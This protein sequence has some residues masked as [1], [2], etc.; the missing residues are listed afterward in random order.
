MAFQDDAVLEAGER[1]SLLKPIKRSISTKPR[2]TLCLP[3]KILLCMVALI[4]MGAFWYI[5]NHVDQRVK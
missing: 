2:E 1:Q 3:G 4:V 5:H